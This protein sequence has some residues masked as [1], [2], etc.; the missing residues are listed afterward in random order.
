MNTIILV[1]ARMGSTRLP[2]KILK[3][4]L[5]KPLL[6]YL[7]ERL[8]RVK[9]AQ[10]IIVATTLE[11]EDEQIVEFCQRH[12]LTCFRGPT[13]DVLK[14]F[15]LATQNRNVENVVRVTAD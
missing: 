10:E 11:P 3:T 7:V 6:E 8:R 5:G 9:L 12:Q 4:V 14:R 15:F 13:N 2:G 1:Q